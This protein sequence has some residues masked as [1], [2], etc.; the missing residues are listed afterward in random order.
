VAIAQLV[1]QSCFGCYMI[2]DL[3]E[4]IHFLGATNDDDFLSGMA[5]CDAVVFPYLEVG[6]SSSGP[7]SQALELGCRVI[8]SRTHTFLQFAKYHKDQIE[9]FDIGSHL[10]LAARIMARPQY[11]AGMRRLTFTVDT[12]KATYL[13]AN[14]AGARR[15][16]RVGDAVR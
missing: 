4:R 15:G 7:I 13:A 6:Q 10:E 8:A 16:R 14:S 11:D 5:I 12:N 9:H 3:S 1:L 2:P